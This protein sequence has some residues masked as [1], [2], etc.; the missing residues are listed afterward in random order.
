MDSKKPG[1]KLMVYAKLKRM[2]T[3]YVDDSL[4]TEDKKLIKGIF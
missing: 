1:L 4:K 2:I 3:S